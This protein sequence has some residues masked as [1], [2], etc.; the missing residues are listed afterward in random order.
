MTSYFENQIHAYEK[1][2]EECYGAIQHG[3]PF[4]PKRVKAEGEEHMFNNCISQG[5]VGGQSPP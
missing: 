3:S 4:K 5:A 2:P 1:L